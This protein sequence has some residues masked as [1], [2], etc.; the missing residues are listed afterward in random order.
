MAVLQRATVKPAAS[1]F[2]FN[3]AVA[4][5][6]MAMVPIFVF[7]EGIPEHRREVQTGH[8]HTTHIC[9]SPFTSAERI[10][11]AW[12]NAQALYNI[13]VRLKESVNWSAHVSPFVALSPA[14]YHEHIIF[15]I[16]SSFY[17]DTRTRSTIGTTRSPRTPSTS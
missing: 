1:V 10:A 15:L 5:F 11:R 4:H 14:V 2:I 13:F 17:H 12:L 7:Q 16:H 9:A 8:P 3:F 6:T